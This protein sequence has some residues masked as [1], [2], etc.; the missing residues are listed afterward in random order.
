MRE[1][2]DKIVRENIWGNICRDC[3]GGGGDGTET[4]SNCGG[5]GIV[6]WQV[7][8]KLYKYILQS[9]EEAI[10]EERE[11]TSKNIWMLRQWLNEDRIDD[12]KKMVT[13][14]DLEYWIN[15]NKSL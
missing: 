5:C 7:T 1:E 9:T 12:Q 6:D 14:E 15:L 3:S 2:V 8:E 10:A 4:C 13:N 11:K